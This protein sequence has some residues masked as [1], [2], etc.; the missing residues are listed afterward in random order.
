MH[1][2]PS[3][4]CLKELFGG[5]SASAWENL[6]A[7][8]VQPCSVGLVVYWWLHAVKQS[9][10]GF[11]LVQLVQA[12]YTVF[13]HVH[14]LV[15][16]VF[17]ALGAVGAQGHCTW[18]ACHPVRSVVGMQWS[19]SVPAVGHCIWTACHPQWALQLHCTLNS[20][21]GSGHVKY[22]EN[23]LACKF[24]AVQS[25]LIQIQCGFRGPCKALNTHSTSI[26]VCPLHLELGSFINR[27]SCLCGG[28]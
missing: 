16:Q 2:T 13:I 21:T 19:F 4:V 18:T 22:Q 10:S 14:V 5:C 1:C 28:V 12:C 25:A 27:F 3:R 24:S 20:V 23:P 15:L 9:A 17:P 7:E 8:H 26:G 6:I 11:R